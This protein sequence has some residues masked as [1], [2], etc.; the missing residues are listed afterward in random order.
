MG[1]LDWSALPTVAEMV[2]FKDIEILVAQL[3]TVRD[4][5]NEQE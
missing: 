4:F 3:S 2:G 1:G 5:Q